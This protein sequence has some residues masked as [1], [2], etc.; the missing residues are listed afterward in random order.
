M[1][2]SQ[3]LELMVL[4][5]SAVGALFLRHGAVIS[6]RSGATGVALAL[7]MSGDRSIRVRSP[8]VP[9]VPRS[10]SAMS[11]SSC[12]FPA[13]MVFSCTVGLQ[14]VCC[15]LFP[16]VCQSMARGGSYTKWVLLVTMFGEPALRLGKVSSP[17][18]GPLGWCSLC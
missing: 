1:S 18:W 8:V 12:P 4:S 14:L 9:R 6:P 11:Q 2:Q 13:L 16:L 15:V 3:Y 10:S 7:V 17:M 5:C